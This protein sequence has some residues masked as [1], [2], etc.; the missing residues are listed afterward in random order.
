MSGI[1]ALDNDMIIQVIQDL[2]EYEF[3]ANLLSVHLNDL[4]LNIDKEKKDEV[5]DVFQIKT[6]E[7]Y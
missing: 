6:K 5:M 7:D 1:E 2:A 4:G 3:C